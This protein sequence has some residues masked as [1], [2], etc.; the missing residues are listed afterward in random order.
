M[1]QQHPSATAYFLYL[2]AG[3]F[4]DH[5]WTQVVGNEVLSVQYPGDAANVSQELAPGQY[6][7]FVAAQGPVDAAHRADAYAV[8]ALWKFT[9]E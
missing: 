1:W 6:A 9:V 3:G 8:S 7:W 4:A 2:T 5:L